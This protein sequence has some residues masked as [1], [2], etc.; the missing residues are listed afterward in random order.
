M[1]FS[2]ATALGST[3]AAGAAGVAA[4][5]C[6]CANVG[7]QKLS[8]ASQVMTGNTTVLTRIGAAPVIRRLPSDQQ[9][10]GRRANLS[11]KLGE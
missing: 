3:A 6:C 5:G 1:R 4:G 7:A 10:I 9:Y 2:A 11:H 8:N